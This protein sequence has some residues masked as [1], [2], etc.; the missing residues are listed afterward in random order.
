MTGAPWLETDASTSTLRNFGMDFFESVLTWHRAPMVHTRHPIKYQHFSQGTADFNQ[1]W[2]ERESSAEYRPQLGEKS[3]YRRLWITLRPSN[4]ENVTTQQ[5]A[6]SLRKES[7]ES[8]KHLI[9]D[10]FDMMMSDAQDSAHRSIYTVI[11]CNFIFVQ[12]FCGAKTWKHRSWR[13]VRQ[14]CD[15]FKVKAS[16]W[17]PRWHGHPIMALKT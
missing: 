5:D 8:R 13:S 6:D 11:S 4:P 10:I 7:G 12:V 14:S 2:A 9:F 17:P 1:A 16:C 15:G 3:L